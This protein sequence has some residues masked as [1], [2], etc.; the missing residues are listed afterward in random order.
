[1]SKALKIAFANARQ[2][3]AERLY[4]YTGIDITR[5]VQVYCLITERCSA[6]CIMCEYWRQ[7]D[8]PEELHKDVWIKALLSLSKIA[9]GMH[10]QFTGGEPFLKEDFIDIIEAIG[11]KGV[12]FGVVTNA[13]LINEKNVERIVATG[14]NN[15]NISIDS[16][17]EKEHDEFRGKPGIYKRAL[18]AIRLLSDEAKKQ[19]RR[20][21]ITIKP[22]L[23]KGNLHQMEKMLKMVPEIGATVLNM[24]PL[25]IK[26]DECTDLLITDE[27]DYEE[28][29]DLLMK[30]KKEGYPLANTKRQ[31]MSWLNT[32]KN[33]ITP[34]LSPCRVG[35]RML[36]IVT[37]GDVY[38]C[39]P[40]KKVF[41]N[42]SKDDTD[43]IW[44]NPSA[45][46]ER[47]RT[48]KCKMLCTASCYADRTLKEKIALFFDMFVKKRK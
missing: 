21:T 44:S 5:P 41:G 14:I 2:E 9:P 34:R 19:N 22:T 33:I 28:V 18:K 42:I 10:V 1:M 17:D 31:M 32:W 25:T 12:S 20:L 23:H 37:N 35:L 11:K 7:K 47:Q 40:M 3:L 30:M 48:V 39:S 45:K 4:I 6:R 8:F 13:E 46:K 15:V 24:Q 26:T 36:T 27:K 43:T 29:V 16:P 38:Y